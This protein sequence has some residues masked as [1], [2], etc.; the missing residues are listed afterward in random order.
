MT[1]AERL[2]YLSAGLM[3]YT[4]LSPGALAFWREELHQEIKRRG[5]V[6]GE[7][8][9]RSIAKDLLDELVQCGMRR[10]RSELGA[11]MVDAN[12]DLL[13]DVV[14]TVLAKTLADLKGL[15]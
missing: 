9:V 2:D 12:P 3:A 6:Q 8:I 4:L 11:R 5:G 15:L 13:D 7:Y 14:S 10:M 1:D